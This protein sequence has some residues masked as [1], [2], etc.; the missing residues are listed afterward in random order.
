MNCNIGMKMNFLEIVLVF[1]FSGSALSKL[2]PFYN[3][4][5]HEMVIKEAS[6]VKVDVDIVS[7]DFG[8][9]VHVDVENTIESRVR[10]ISMKATGL[11]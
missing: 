7:K 2:P 9:G 5:H 10:V 1:A 3:P 6:D 4:K 11:N 8:V